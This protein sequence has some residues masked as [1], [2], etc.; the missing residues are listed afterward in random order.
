MKNFGLFLFVSV[1]LFFLCS[2]KSNTYT[3]GLYISQ[4]NSDELVHIYEDLVILRVRRP[5]S[6]IGEN[7]FWEWGGRYSINEA[8]E[9]EFDM[10]E[11]EK[12]DWNFYYVF[13]V[14]TNG[15]IMVE[16]LS[17]TEKSYVLRRKPLQRRKTV[18]G[19][20]QNVEDDYMAY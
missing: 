9:F 1:T 15:G 16:N 8:G 11:D 18:P 19:P 20:M 12:R 3:N 10:D 6:M 14:H 7:V 13:R 5:D 4:K 17:D 2:C